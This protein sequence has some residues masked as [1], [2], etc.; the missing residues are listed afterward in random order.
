MD[1]SFETGLTA[2]KIYSAL[3]GE[4]TKSMALPELKKKIKDKTFD[5][6]VGWLLRE[7]KIVLDAEGKKLLVRLI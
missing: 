7:N 2:G 1:Y 6:A 3:D 5:Y 4:A